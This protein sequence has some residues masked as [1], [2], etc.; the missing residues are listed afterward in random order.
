VYLILFKTVYSPPLVGVLDPILVVWFHERYVHAK[1]VQTRGQRWAPKPTIHLNN[2]KERANRHEVQCFNEELG[3]NEV[4]TMGGTAFN[5]EV[6]PS[7]TYIVL[8][9]AFSCRCGKPRQYLKVA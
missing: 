8:L 4:T 2:T 5:G 6:R 1:A 9:D 3:N 7:R